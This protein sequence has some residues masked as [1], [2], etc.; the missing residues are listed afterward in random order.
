[1]APY[2]P[3]SEND[4]TAG[5]IQ[6]V[7]NVI[8]EMTKEFDTLAERCDHHS[9]FALTYLRTTEEYRR[10]STEPGFFADPSFVNH[11]DAV[12]ADYYFRAWDDWT[13]GRTDDVPDAWRIAF[14]AAD[15]RKVRSRANVSLG[16][17]AHVNRDLPFVLASIG[18]VTPDG[19]S[20]KPD[21]DKVNV[22]LNRV[23]EPVLEELAA[24]FDPTMDDADSPYHLTYTAL[25]QQ[26]AA[27]RETAWRNAE[28]LVNAPDAAARA[29][30]A[31]EIEAYA[32]ASAR[33]ISRAAPTNRR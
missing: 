6:C 21:H 22:F 33:D 8:R 5:R 10:A 32:A 18:L 30:V 16:I 29:Q 17:N 7:D 28:R 25:F 1:M 9:I 13:A 20:R 15:G 19:A 31:Q 3:S 23:T 14:A 11:E 12:F 26:I 24:R 4:C 2:N 27:W